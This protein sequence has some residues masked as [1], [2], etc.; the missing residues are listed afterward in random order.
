MS[1]KINLQ[2]GD[3]QPLLPF[4]ADDPLGKNI[5]LEEL[6]NAVSYSDAELEIADDIHIGLT[7]YCSQSEAIRQFT[8]PFEAD[9]ETDQGDE[10]STQN[11]TVVVIKRD[12]LEE[13]GTALANNNLLL[14]IRLLDTPTEDNRTV[15]LELMIDPDIHQGH[16]H[17]FTFSPKVRGINHLK[18]ETT[19]LAEEGISCKLYNY[20]RTDFGNERNPVDNDKQLLEIRPNALN[21]PLSKTE[22]DRII[23]SM[24]RRAEGLLWPRN[25]RGIIPLFKSEQIDLDYGANQYALVIEGEG[26]VNKYTITGR[27]NLL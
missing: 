1:K 11:A 16:H 7:V 3:P 20:D 14:D 18:I 6:E 21:A 12:I 13:V 8:A 15:I 25:G 2:F 17:V 27:L 4:N 19:A 24:S 22:F 10:D 26:A 5:S 23:Q 9:L